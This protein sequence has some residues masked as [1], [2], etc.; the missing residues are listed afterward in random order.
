[1]Q[2]VVLVLQ[3]ASQECI[4]KGRK[5]EE[6]A[7]SSRQ[8]WKTAKRTVGCNARKGMTRNA[9]QAIENSNAQKR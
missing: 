1:M 3:R 6:T 8:T 2:V 4:K 5:A 9:N 7:N